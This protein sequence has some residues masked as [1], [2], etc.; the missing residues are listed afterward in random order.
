MLAAITCPACGHRGFIAKPKLPRALCC[1][2]CQDEAWFESGTPLPTGMA[3]SQL[4]ERTS[5]TTSQ[6]DAAD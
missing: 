4:L 1:S 5:S 6:A 2:R 3:L